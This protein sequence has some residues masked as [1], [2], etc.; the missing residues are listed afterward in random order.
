MS[1]PI[2]GGGSERVAPVAQAAGNNGTTPYTTVVDEAE[3]LDKLEQ[4]QNHSNE[5]VYKKAMHILETYFGLDDDE[6]DGLARETTQQGFVF[7]G[8]VQQ[9]MAPPGG[10]T[11]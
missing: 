1:G 11:L 7:R 8:G 10:Y 9:P 6:D 3:G 2:L 4:L 5:D